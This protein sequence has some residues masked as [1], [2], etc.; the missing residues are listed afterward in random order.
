MILDMVKKGSSKYSVFLMGFQLQSQERHA[1]FWIHF[2]V[3]A[4]TFVSF[5]SSCFLY[6][7]IFQSF[8]VALLTVVN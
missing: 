3:S 7:I 1:L 4:E 8:Q 6:G 2:Q 5:H